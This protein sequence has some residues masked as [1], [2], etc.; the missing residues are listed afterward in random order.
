MIKEESKKSGKENETRQRGGSQSR[1]NI[2]NNS[3]TASSGQDT[4]GLPENDDEILRQLNKMTSD[5]L[6]ED[7]A[8]NLYLMQQQEKVE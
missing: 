6:N 3:I 5:F 7:R 8:A 2:N 4:T 1:E